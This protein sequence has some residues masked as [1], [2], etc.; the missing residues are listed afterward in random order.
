MKQ[1]H[2]PR[3]VSLRRVD[4]VH[5]ACTRCGRETT[6]ARWVAPVAARVQA[7]LGCGERSVPVRGTPVPERQQR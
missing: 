6:I 3:L 7:C 2:R 5:A 1:P 4:L